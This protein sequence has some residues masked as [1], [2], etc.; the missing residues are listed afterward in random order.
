M[1]NEGKVGAHG[2]H[3]PHKLRMAFLEAIDNYIATDH[4]EFPDTIEYRGCNLSVDQICGHLWNCTDIVPLMYCSDLADL[5]P[6]VSPVRSNGWS[7]AQAA[8][9]L[10]AHS[11][12][13]M[14]NVTPPASIRKTQRKPSRDAQRRLPVSP[15]TGGIYA[16][17]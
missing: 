14:W 16:E 15:L 2:G 4:G 11:R 6:P 9:V 17:G 1:S 12:G 3:A 5:V 10:R 8:R 13:G 7:Y